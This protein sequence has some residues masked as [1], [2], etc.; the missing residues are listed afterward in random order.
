MHIYREVIDAIN[1]KR[2]VKGVALGNLGQKLKSDSLSTESPF[3]WGVLP[4]LNC[5]SLILAKRMKRSRYTI[6]YNLL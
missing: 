2:D 6:F 4:F 1:F 3:R 5:F